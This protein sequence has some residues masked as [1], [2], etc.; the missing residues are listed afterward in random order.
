VLHQWTDLQGF[1]SNADETEQPKKAHASPG[2][3]V[4]M[5]RLPLLLAICGLCIAAPAE[6]RTWNFRNGQTMEA[7]YVR[8]LFDKIIIRDEAGEERTIPKDQFVLSDADVEYLELENPPPFDLSFKKSIEQKNFSLIRGAEDRPPEW[9]GTFGVKVEQ[10]GGPDFNHELTVEFFAIG[11]EL[12]GNRYILLDRMSEKFTPTRANKRTL[13]FNSKRL[14]RMTD[15]W[16]DSLVYSRRGEQ[17]F[18]FLI[19]VKDPRG[20]V[21]AIDGSNDWL[22]QN[23]ENLEKLGIRN[24][25]DKTCT[26]T[27]PTRPKSYIGNREAGRL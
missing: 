11:K 2:R 22:A 9:R 13:E 1:L 10:K 6:M 12:E 8:D 7:E 24:Y 3:E 17:Y 26:R 23:L 19:T 25:F 16:G 27:Y 14:V 5:S 18:G 21:I 20:K 15:M 4:A